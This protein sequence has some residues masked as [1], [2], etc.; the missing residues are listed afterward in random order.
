MPT[1]YTVQPGDCLLSLAAKAGIPYQRIGQHSD[2]QALMNKRP[3]PSMLLPGDEITIPDLEPMQYPRQTEQRHRFVKKAS[4]VEI[5]VR[6]CEYGEP[7]RN[8]PYHV[9]VDGK[10]YK[11]RRPTTD[12]DG[13]VVCEIPADADTATVV[14]GVTQ[15]RYELAL[16]HID[17]PDTAEGLM[18][19]LANLGHYQGVVDGDYD[20]ECIEAIREFLT[21]REGLNGD[22]SNAINGDVRSRLTRRYGS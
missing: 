4:K 19:R 1:R 8:E 9:E 17:P 16:G 12:A 21:L 18:G 3:N 13:M 11:G 7:R 5:R 14:I 2:N 15:D 6:L 10:V 22:A 20:A